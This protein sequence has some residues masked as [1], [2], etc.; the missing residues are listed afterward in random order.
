MHLCPYAWM[1]SLNLVDAY[2][3][4]PINGLMRKFVAFQI[5]D[6]TCQG[7]V[8]PFGFSLAL[9]EFTKITK[10]LLAKLSQKGVHFLIYLE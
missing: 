8:L 3:H 2:W 7:K 9:Q 4:V 10:P 1:A 6:K 5:E